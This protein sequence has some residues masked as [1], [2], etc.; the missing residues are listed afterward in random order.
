M[1]AKSFVVVVSLPLMLAI[2]R[3]TRGGG[4]GRD[5]VRIPSHAGTASADPAR[6]AAPGSKC[7][8]R[9]APQRCR[10]SRPRW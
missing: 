5:V 7:A 8:R 10:S 2:F 1:V 9:R 3:R 6:S 4:F